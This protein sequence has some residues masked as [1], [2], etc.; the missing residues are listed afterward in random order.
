MD[1]VFDAI[2]SALSVAVVAQYTWSMNG[3]F[4]SNGVPRGAVLISAVVI[5]TTLM[6]L[7]LLW[8]GPQPWPAQVVGLLLEA[9]GLAL[10]WAAIRVSRAARLR[11]AFDAENPH[12]FVTEGPYKYLRHPFYTSYV[13]FWIGWAIA[14]WSPWAAIPLV[15]IVTIYVVAARG[16]ERKFSMTPMADAYAAY[17]RRAGFFWPRISG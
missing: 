3:H 8:L 1:F 13:I 11:L 7:A 15:A 17:K 16:E 5:V 4:S 14:A 10:F 6:L 12:S 2:V 9:G